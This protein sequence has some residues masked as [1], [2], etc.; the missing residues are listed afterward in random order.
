MKTFNKIL[1]LTGVAAIGT[2]YAKSDDKV[3]V[4]TDAY[5]WKGDTVFQ[6]EF[7]AW[8]VNP[9]EIHST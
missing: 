8:A 1:I 2:L 9:Y 7:K 5:I 4:S 6:D 3:I